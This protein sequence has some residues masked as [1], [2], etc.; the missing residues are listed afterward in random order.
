M[1]LQEICARYYETVYHRCLY[2]L[3]FDQEAAK[4]VTQQVFLVFVLLNLNRNL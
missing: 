1:T 4:E 3:S 2:N